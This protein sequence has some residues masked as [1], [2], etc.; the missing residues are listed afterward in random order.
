MEALAERFSG[1]EVTT[2]CHRVFDCAQPGLEP[3][4]DDA[5]VVVIRRQPAKGEEAKAQ[6]G[7]SG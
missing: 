3:I 7:A 1:G 2:L 5:T 6:S 4:K